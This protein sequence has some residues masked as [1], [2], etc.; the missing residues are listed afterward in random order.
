MFEEQKVVNCCE[1]TR[2]KIGIDL[3]MSRVEQGVEV[4]CDF[5]WELIEKKKT[6]HF[7]VLVEPRVVDFCGFR[8]M[9]NIIKNKVSTYVSSIKYSTRKS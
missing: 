9:R 3:I 7:V 2:F 5:L 8:Q 6:C 1:V 4:Y